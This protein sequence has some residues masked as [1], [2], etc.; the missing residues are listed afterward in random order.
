LQT[1]ITPFT[2]VLGRKDSEVLSEV[3]DMFAAWL[4][5]DIA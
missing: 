2:F 3:I 5:S 1:P 4:D